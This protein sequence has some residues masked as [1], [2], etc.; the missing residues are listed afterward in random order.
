MA[1]RFAATRHATLTLAGRAV[2]VCWMERMG[3]ALQLELRNWR[4]DHRE[5]LLCAQNAFDLLYLK[6][7]DL[8][9]RSCRIVSTALRGLC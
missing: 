5:A 4:V 1:A 7:E 9:E 6:G 8:R 3:G 2:L